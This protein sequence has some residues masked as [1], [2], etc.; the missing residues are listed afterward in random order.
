MDKGRVTIAVGFLVI[1][2]YTLFEIATRFA[3]AGMI[4]GRPQ[5]NAALF[6]LITAI[7]LLLVTGIWILQNLRAK[8]AHVEHAPSDEEDLSARSVPAKPNIHSFWI[9]LI[10]VLYILFVNIVGYLVLTPFALTAMLFVLGVRNLLYG[11]AVSIVTTFVF[12]YLFGGLMNII[13]PVGRFGWY[14]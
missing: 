3:E 10:L 7:L 14:I 11:F 9:L 8:G 12:Y 5:N 1:G 6:P 4:G 13:L 2:G